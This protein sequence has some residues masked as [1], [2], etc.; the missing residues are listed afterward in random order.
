MEPRDL[1]ADLRAK[2]MEDANNGDP[3]D[4]LSQNLF[5]HVNSEQRIR[6]LVGLAIE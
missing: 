2:E 4:C 5:D 3:I 1:R 6:L